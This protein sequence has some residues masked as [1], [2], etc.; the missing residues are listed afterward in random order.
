MFRTIRL[1]LRG[2]RDVWEE[3]KKEAQIEKDNVEGIKV[4]NKVKYLGDDVP[5]EELYTTDKKQY[6]AY[7]ENL[8]EA[9]NKYY[10]AKAKQYDKERKMNL[11]EAKKNK[12]AK[13]PLAEADA[14]KE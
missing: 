1:L 6:I 8:E 9:F 12:K 5:D 13:K 3:I 10:A 2:P 7:Q 4:I 14:E 11:K